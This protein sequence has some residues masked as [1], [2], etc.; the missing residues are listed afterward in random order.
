[1]CVQ[2]GKEDFGVSAILFFVASELDL[3]RLH[4]HIFYLLIFALRSIHIYMYVG[5]PRL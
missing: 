5:N 1:M 2:H 3:A 4:A